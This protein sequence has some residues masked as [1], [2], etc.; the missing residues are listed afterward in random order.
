MS[1]F[2]SLIDVT[3]SH[4]VL[5]WGAVISDLA[6]GVLEKA[7]GSVILGNCVNNCSHLHGRVKF[8][9]FLLPSCL[10]PLTSINSVR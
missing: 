2:S 7:V 1:N 4:F 6:S 9:C 8:W 5:F 3:L 10:S